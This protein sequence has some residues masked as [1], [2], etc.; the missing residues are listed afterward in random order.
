MPLQN[1]IFFRIEV[2]PLETFAKGYRLLSLSLGENFLPE[3]HSVFLFE[4]Y[5]SV[6]C[7]SLI[8]VDFRVYQ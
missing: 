2:I 4:S 6:V 8:P 3:S 7:F 1:L 5:P